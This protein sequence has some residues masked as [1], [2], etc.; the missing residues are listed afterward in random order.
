MSRIRM[1]VFK[2][3]IYSASYADQEGS[4]FATLRNAYIQGHFFSRLFYLV[5]EKTK[6]I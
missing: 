5:G 3:G 1:R 6:E 2:S 4:G